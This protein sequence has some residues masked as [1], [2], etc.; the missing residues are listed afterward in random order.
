MAG[1]FELQLPKESP[2]RSNDAPR[3]SVA[4][5]TSS[6]SRMQSPPPHVSAREIVNQVKEKQ[7]QQEAQRQTS[8]SSHFAHASN[9]FSWRRKGATLPQDSPAP[10]ISSDS[11]N[12][13][14]SDTMHYSSTHTA[15]RDLTRRSATTT[16]KARRSMTQSPRQSLSLD[17]AVSASTTVTSPAV[18]PNTPKHNNTAT[19][20]LAQA[21]FSLSIPSIVFPN[22]SPSMASS[23][24]RKKKD[25][26]VRPGTSHG[27][28]SPSSSPAASHSGKGPVRR[29]KSFTKLGDAVANQ[30]MIDH[31]S[32]S[33]PGDILVFSRNPSKGSALTRSMPE[34]GSSSSSAVATTSS[35]FS[36]FSKG[37]SRE[38]V[39]D[40]EDVTTTVAQNS[41]PPRGRPDTASTAHEAVHKERE[42]SLTRRLTWWPRRRADSSV[43]PT[44]APPTPPPPI[45]ARS[46]DRPAPVKVFVPSL[47]S[48]RPFSPLLNDK[49]SRDP[50]D[51]KDAKHADPQSSIKRRHSLSGHSNQSHSTIKPIPSSRPTSQ[52]FSASH[53]YSLSLNTTEHGYML[54]D[55]ALT[56]SP[57]PPSIPLD[58]SSQASSFALAAPPSPST[59]A[60]TRSNTQTSSNSLPQVNRDTPLLL[61]QP[62]NRPTL[63]TEPL[64]PFNSMRP[65]P[66]QW[67]QEIPNNRASTPSRSQS[68][69]VTSSTPENLLANANKLLS[70]T[71]LNGNSLSS[72]PPPAV[73][74]RLLRRLSTTLFP[75]STTPM[76]T[77]P[78]ERSS[79]EL[80]SSFPNLIN[81]VNIASGI[82]TPRTSAGGSS[83]SRSK[84]N[85]PPFGS[86]RNSAEEAKV[87]LPKITSRLPDETA[88]DF[89]FRLL[90]TVTRA[91]VA[92]VLASRYIY[93]LS[94]L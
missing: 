19:S 38:M 36:F 88:E 64:D 50:F 27:H 26:L 63:S 42:K 58:G 82:T 70:A 6:P 83:P 49:N 7:R 12:G 79:V 91:E 86:T 25:A 84:E 80:S 57:H 75:S 43:A 30:E 60:R 71:T 78:I 20:A 11:L 46:Q 5:F 77:T 22:P 10:R 18:N 53:R 44:P 66:A 2:R 65:A 72:T 31:G 35:T 47:P 40:R 74:N 8:A 87:K 69:P 14:S 56:Q 54:S 29:V 90:S 61:R 51:A 76:L 85:L 92:H 73:S 4:A 34:H 81:G 59:S 55:G 13:Y 39:A 15:I 37:K 33:T 48:F 23:I 41:E 21:G 9:L 17:A 28:G 89:L 93:S 3:A 24:K 45:P 32:S 68:D 52:T 1:L 16:T 67:Q 94:Y 62:L